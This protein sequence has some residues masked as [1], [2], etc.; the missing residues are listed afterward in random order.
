M[1]LSISVEDALPRP[2]PPPLTLPRSPTSA[3]S[4]GAAAPTPSCTSL[5]STPPTS[6]PASTSWPRRARCTSSPRRRPQKRRAGAGGEGE[7]GGSPCPHP[8]GVSLFCSGTL[9]PQKSSR[10]GNCGQTWNSFGRLVAEPPP[11]PHPRPTARTHTPQVLKDLVEMCRGV[12]HPTRGLFL[13]AYL[14]QC[15]KVGGKGRKGGR[16]GGMM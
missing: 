15:T 13:R 7:G 4:R 8:Y 10:I 2:D 9:A 3:R 16:D 14:L 5:S 12:Q 11:P 1:P 6:C